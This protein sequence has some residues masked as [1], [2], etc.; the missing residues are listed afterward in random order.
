MLNHQ[1][2]FQAKC[3]IAHYHDA[4]IRG[5]PPIPKIIWFISVPYLYAILEYHG[6]DLCVAFKPL[7]AVQ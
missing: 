5:H 4:I 7:L 3:G 1:T 6:Q 2:I